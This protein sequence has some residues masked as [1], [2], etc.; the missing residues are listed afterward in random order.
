MPRRSN[1][2]QRMVAIL[3]TI[4]SEEATVTES[5][6]LTDQ[7]FGVQREVDICV[8][9]RMAGRP[10]TISIECRDHRRRQSVSWVEEMHAKHERL[11]TD[12]LV[13]VS[14][15]GF[16]TQALATA[17]SYGHH[18]VTPDAITPGFV[19]EIVNNVTTLL[20]QRMVLETTTICL[21]FTVDRRLL[22]CRVPDD[23]PLQRRDG[24]DIGTAKT[25]VRNVLGRLTP[26]ELFRDV[27]GDENCFTV[28]CEKPCMDGDP[29]FAYV[30]VKPDSPPPLL[31]VVKAIFVGSAAIYS[32]DVHLTHGR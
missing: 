12:V 2:F 26:E 32:A 14:S 30:P 7:V 15:S 18:L 4:L 8:E 20:A 11:P 9:G 16:S 1:D 25:L 22:I 13:L 28:R 3:E 19:G 24:A 31:R 21:G 23:F 6:M 5:K 10:V 17:E 29:V 27:E